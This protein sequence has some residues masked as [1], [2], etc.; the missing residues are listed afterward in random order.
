MSEIDEAE[1]RQL[2][3]RIGPPDIGDGDAVYPVARLMIDGEDALADVGKWRLGPW[4]AEQILTADAPLLPALPPRRVIVYAGWPDPDGLAPKIGR[5]D[6][7]V[8]WSDFH[9]VFEISDAPLDF[10]E[11]YSWAPVPVPDMLFDAQ[12]YT[13]EVQRATAAREWESVPWQTALLLHSYLRESPITP[14]D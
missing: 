7:V 12:Q 3:I 11:A 13:A 14:G 9:T 2:E 10:A 5:R 6:D 8:V 1:I 4:P